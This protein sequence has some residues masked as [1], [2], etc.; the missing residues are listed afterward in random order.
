MARILV[1]DDEELARF[2]IREILE[3]AGHEVTE[4]TTAPVSTWPTP[5]SCLNPSGVFTAAPS[6]KE[7]ASAWRPVQRI[8]GR[9][10]GRVWAEAAVEK[11]ATVY[12]TL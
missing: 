1:V 7:P 9:H 11:G 3:S 6:S 5:T 12:F 4:A 8:I 10:G 2:T